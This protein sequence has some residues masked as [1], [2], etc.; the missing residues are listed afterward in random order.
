MTKPVHPAGSLL[1]EETVADGH[2]SFSSV[3]TVH[4]RFSGT[5][6]GSGHLIVAPGAEVR[7]RIRAR[8]LTIAGFVVGDCHAEERVEMLTSARLVGNITTRVLKIAD[9]VDFE[10]T[11]DMI[12]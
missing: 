1:A 2:L 3:I 12:R 9:G 10:G 7:A 6:E 4:G 8:V 11:C 5:I